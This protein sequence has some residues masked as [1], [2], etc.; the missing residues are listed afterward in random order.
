MVDFFRGENYLENENLSQRGKRRVNYGAL[1]SSLSCLCGVFISW[2][3]NWI[4]TS[5]LG[6]GVLV[7]GVI[8]IFNI[9]SSM[10]E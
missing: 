6:L 2:G 9:W 10:T 1:F 3:N 4:L 5:I 7:C 8:G